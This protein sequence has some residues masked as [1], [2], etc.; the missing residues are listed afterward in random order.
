MLSS[1]YTGEGQPKNDLTV[2]VTN[3]AAGETATAAAKTIRVTDPPAS[4]TSGLSNNSSSLSDLMSQ[5][6]AGDS[7]SPHHG[8]AADTSSSHGFLTKTNGSVAGNIA[9]LIEGHM[10]SP[11]A[12]LSGGAAGL[13]TNPLTSSDHKAFLT[14]PSHG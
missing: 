11:I 3:T 6:S 2:T 14:H 9:S 1:S 4:A 12:A 5:F 7:S 10:A 8:S 13:L